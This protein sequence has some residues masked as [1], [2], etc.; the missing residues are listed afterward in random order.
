MAH[1]RASTFSSK[2]AGKGLTKTDTQGEQIPA[3]FLE[4]I[5][6]CILS[7]LPTQESELGPT[8]RGKQRQSSGH[9]EPRATLPWSSVTWLLL[10]WGLLFP[11]AKGNINTSILYQLTS[12]SPPCFLS[13]SFFHSL[14]LSS[15]VC[16]SL[17]LSLSLL[18]PS[19]HLLSLLSIQRLSYLRLP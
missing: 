5:V 17:C 7:G 3:V 4:A 16:L 18:P 11:A 2:T 6:F 13:L 10:E 8:V 15:S 12:F 14:S 19:P 1:E 9:T